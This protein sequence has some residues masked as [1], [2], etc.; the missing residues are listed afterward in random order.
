MTRVVCAG[1]VNWDV[2]LHVDALPDPD[3]E[4]VI[5]EQS[6][7]AGGSAANTAA[8]LAGLGI[9]TALLGSVG[10]DDNGHLARRELETAGVDC[11]PVV[12]VGDGATTV[13]YLVVDAQGEVMVL[14]NDGVN[15]R[16]SAEDLDDSLLAGADHLHLTGQSPATAEALAREASNENVPVSV[17]PGRRID[18]RDF[19]GVVADAQFLFLNDRE[20]RQAQKND[21]L[22]TTAATQVISRGA[23]GGEIR[24]GTETV[25]H[26]GFDVDVVDTAGAG[27]AFAAG[28]LA[29]HL[30]GRDLE[31]TLTVA[32]A[33]GALAARQAGARSSPSW[34]GVDALRTDA[35]HSRE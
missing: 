34:E 17:D 22:A 27:D 35:L 31:E 14:A 21:L 7:A 9:E 32:N 18:D 29:A 23:S 26:P 33:T 8:A 25:S 10:D 15:E 3:G 4:G 2:T 19:H 5:D 24:R 30:D 6:Q 16:F 28:F 12:E 11:T 20:A 1:H 13:K